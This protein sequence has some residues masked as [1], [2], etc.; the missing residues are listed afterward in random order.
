MQFSSSVVYVDYVHDGA[1]CGLLFSDI[2]YCALLLVGFIMME[3]QSGEK[4]ERRMSC[5][6]F[7]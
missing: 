5:G 1:M 4:T 3:R 6:F 2:F 7:N